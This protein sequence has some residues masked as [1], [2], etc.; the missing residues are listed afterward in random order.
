[1]DSQIRRPRQIAYDFIYKKGYDQEEV[2]RDVK[3]LAGSS[4]PKK[5]KGFL[6]TIR[7]YVEGHRRIYGKIKKH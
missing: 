1:M 3:V 6:K 7:F 5:L 4:D 2:T